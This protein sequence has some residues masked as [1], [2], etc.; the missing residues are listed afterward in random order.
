VIDSLMLGEFTA[1]CL[2]ERAFVGMQ[3]RLTAGVRNQLLA[4]IFRG[5]DGHMEGAC[6]AAALN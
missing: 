2:I 3:A 5:D 6:R 1:D 4:D